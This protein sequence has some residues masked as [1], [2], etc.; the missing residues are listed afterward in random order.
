MDISG[1]GRGCQPVPGEPAPAIVLVPDA[2]GLMPQVSRNASG[3]QAD[4]AAEGGEAG[5]QQRVLVANQFA[6]R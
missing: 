1:D 2:C 4:G 3:V 6:G 5:D